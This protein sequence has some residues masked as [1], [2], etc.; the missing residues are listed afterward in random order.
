MPTEQEQQQ[1]NSL[2]EQ[3]DLG[4]EAPVTSPVSGASA[5]GAAAP[6]IPEPPAPT[7]RPRDPATGRF[8]PL[9]FTEPAD[10]TLT[11]PDPE[12][13]APLSHVRQMAEDFGIDHASLPDEAVAQAVRA[14][15]RTLLRLQQTDGRRAELQQAIDRSRESAPAPPPVEQPH[16]LAEEFGLT[17]EEASQFDPDFT[18][19]LNRALGRAI[20]PLSERLKAAEDRVKQLTSGFQAQVGESMERA[21]DRAFAILDDPRLGGRKP[22][23]ELPAGSPERRRRLALVREAES[24]AGKGAHYNA[25]AAKVAGARDAVLGAP[26][27]EPKPT[28]KP[29]TAQ[30]APAYTEEQWAAASL[31]RPTHRAGAQEPNG[32]ARATQAIADLQRELNGQPTAE[33]DSAE[34]FPD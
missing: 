28:P 10:A 17:P 30:T 11:S 29:A 25:I 33:P 5:E 31:R 8:L 27:P 7:E 6:T 2:A 20:R 12:P 16:P 23:R 1:N 32:V 14:T 21:F 4:E 13:P 19:A 24:E 9:N 22:L 15:Q 34:D 3:Y 18:K 26:A